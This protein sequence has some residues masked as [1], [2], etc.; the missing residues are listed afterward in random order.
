MGVDVVSQTLLTE[1]LPAVETEYR[2]SGSGMTV[3]LPASR[4][5]RWRVWIF[6]SIIRNFAWVGS[7]SAGDMLRSAYPLPTN[8]EKTQFRLLWISCGTADAL[9]ETNRQ[10]IT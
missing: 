3:R 10:L 5:V 6:P 7:F 4:W 1:V 9:F 2:V 8:P